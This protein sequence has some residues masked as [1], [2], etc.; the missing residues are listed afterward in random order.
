MRIWSIEMLNVDVCMQ[1]WMSFCQLLFVL[2]VCRGVNVSYLLGIPIFS[3]LV[4][5]QPL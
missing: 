2:C 3:L 5:T 1:L 4:P